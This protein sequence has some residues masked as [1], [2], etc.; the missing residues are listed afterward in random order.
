MRNLYQKLLLLTI[1]SALC[2]FFLQSKLRK[3]PFLIGRR[4]YSVEEIQEHRKANIRSVCERNNLINTSFILDEK[5]A[6]QL[7][8]EH[9]HKF[10][11]CEVPKAGCS[12]WKRIIILLN[13]S[14]DL[15]ANELEHYQ[16][17]SSKQ[18]VKLSSYSESLQKELLANYT[19]VMFTRGPLERI[20][21]AFRDK[22]LHTDDVYYSTTYANIIKS[23][24]GIE[25]KENITF[26]QF[27]HFITQEN[28]VRDTHWKP[29]Y[30]L[31]D[32]C[33]IQYDFIGKFKTLSQDADYVLR[34]I[35][36]PPNLKY[37]TIKHH[38]NDSRTNDNLS[39]SYLEMLPPILFRK[40][41]K[42]YSLD[43][44]MFEYSYYNS[45]V[46][47]LPKTTYIY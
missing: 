3:H 16:V 9:S 41:M 42:V 21:S 10:I 18:L 7:Y 13:E 30:Q 39:I 35:G 38:S 27:V 14:V 5:V 40:L 29:M 31:C 4:Q 33:N 22:F 34:S 15:T 23:V 25:S 12:N 17:H 1:S 46:F 32:P 28:P 19:K 43:F 8:V 2:V 24:L 26:E 44:P 36:A 6:A 11:Y 20:V 37:P 45:S 47:R